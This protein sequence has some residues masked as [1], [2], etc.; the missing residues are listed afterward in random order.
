MYKYIFLL[1]PKNQSADLLCV[2]SSKSKRNLVRCRHC[3]RYQHAHCVSKGQTDLVDYQCPECW[4]KVTT[5]IPSAATFIVSPPSIKMQWQKEIEKHVS[6]DEG[7]KVLVYDGIKGSGWW[8]PSDLASYDI[9]LT[10]YN[11][12]RDELYYLE[13]TN[14]PEHMRRKPQF[15]IPKSPLTMVEWWRVCLDEAQMIEA[16]IN[17]SSKMVK[18]LPGRI[19][20][21]ICFYKFI[22]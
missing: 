14:R 15:M 4:S 7:F 20:A 13:S 3:D 10:D 18:H 6:L 17:R 19:L 5:I 1:E 8:S 9:I 2:C 12:L 11:V 21:K 22:C 16:P